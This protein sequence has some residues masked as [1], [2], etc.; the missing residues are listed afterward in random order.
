MKIFFVAMKITFFQTFLLKTK[1]QLFSEWIKRKTRNVCVFSDRPF[2]L[3]KS[4]ET[5]ENAENI[6]RI[7]VCAWMMRVKGKFKGSSLNQFNHLSILKENYQS[8]L[9]SHWNSLDNLIQFLLGA[10]QVSFNLLP[11]K[12]ATEKGH[13]MLLQTRIYLWHSVYSSLVSIFLS[14]FLLVFLTLFLGEKYWM[15]VIENIWNF[16]PLEKRW[17][18]LSDNNW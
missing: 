13:R 11:K 5:V 4:W 17:K 1:K 8:T 6:E 18:C 14:F 7:F 10:L 3:W 9:E 16:V 15:S 2:L 12:I